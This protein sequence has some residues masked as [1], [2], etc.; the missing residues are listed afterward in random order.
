MRSIRKLR[1]CCVPHNNFVINRSLSFEAFQLQLSLFLP[2]F[3]PS[4]ATLPM[5]KFAVGTPCISNSFMII[6]KD[7]REWMNDCENMPNTCVAPCCSCFQFT[8]RWM[9][10]TNPRNNE[11]ISL[12]LLITDL[13]NFS[14]TINN[15]SCQFNST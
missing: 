14:K 15:R 10:S 9:H 12:K 11:V 4:C 13:V 5:G 7:P 2:R 6:T 3:F 1:F 8:R